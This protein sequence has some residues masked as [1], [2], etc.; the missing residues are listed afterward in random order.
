MNKKQFSLIEIIA[1]LVLLSILSVLAS[2]LIVP[3]IEGF[4]LAKKNAETSQKAQ[5]AMTR[6]IKELSQ[7]TAQPTIVS[8]TNIAFSRDGDHN[9]TWNSSN[10]LLMLDSNTLCDQ[11]ETFLVTSINSQCLEIKLV[12]T[13]APNIEFKTRIC[14]RE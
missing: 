9:I 3:M 14:I 8:T 13:N 5:I 1:V 11:V 6:I 7:E 2:M 10:K 4:T 12:L